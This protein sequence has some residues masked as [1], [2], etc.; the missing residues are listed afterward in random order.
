[1]STTPH[2]ALFKR[3][4]SAPARAAE[5]LRSVLPAEVSAR[6][7]WDE[8]RPESGE[9]TD[10]D[11]RGHLADLLFSAPTT[12]GR[13]AL[14][15]LLFEHQSTPDPLMPVRLLIYTSR[16][17]SDWLRNNKGARK[18]PPVFSVVLHHGSS[19]WTAPTDL[20]ELY[21][22]DLDLLTAAGPHLPA[23]QLVLDDLSAVPDEELRARA[24]SA[25]VRLALL[26]L[27]H[28]RDSY[29]IDERLDQCDELASEV[30]ESESGLEALVIMARY[31]AQVSKYAT[32]EGVRAMLRLLPK[33]QA[34]EVIMTMGRQLI[35]QGEQQGIEKGIAQGERKLLLR[36]LERRFGELPEA[37]VDRVNAANGEQLERWADQI[38][39]A[40]SIDDVLT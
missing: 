23:L 9:F 3:T 40:E 7:Q 30:V 21:D 14:L 15:Y 18:V 25:L 33:S 6:I 16:I 12:D 31:V 13:R 28:A 19:G 4:F 38:L 27:K 24:K 17:W 39:D 32:R 10:E 29:D 36:L 8:L 1:M 34:D 35:E 26:L 2:D 22:A 11:L 37:V 5:E 20:M